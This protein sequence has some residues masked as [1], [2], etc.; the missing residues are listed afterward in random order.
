[1]ALA[2]TDAI[3][4]AHPLTSVAHCGSDGGDLSLASGLPIL[5]AAERHVQLTRGD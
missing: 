1:M 4:M 2:S 3:V 5:L